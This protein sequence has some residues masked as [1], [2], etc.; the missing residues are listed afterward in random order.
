MQYT[1]GI[2]IV[3]LAD[4]GSPDVTIGDVVAASQL[5]A[6]ETG[7]PET[8]LPAPRT[9]RVTAPSGDVRIIWGMPFLEAITSGPVAA[10]D[11]TEIVE[12]EIASAGIQSIQHVSGFGRLE[13][14]GTLLDALS[15]DATAVPGVTLVAGE[16]LLVGHE[17]MW[18][19][20]TRL[21]RERPVSHLIGTAIRR[22]HTQASLALAVSRMAKRAADVRARAGASRRRGGGDE[23]PFVVLDADSRRALAPFARPRTWLQ[24]LTA[25]DIE[26]GTVGGINADEDEIDT[27]LDRI[28]AGANIVIDRSLPGMISVSTPAIAGG[29]QV[30]SYLATAVYDEALNRITLTVQS[31]GG[32]EPPPSSIIYWVAPDPLPR[33]A[34][35]VRVSANGGYPGYLVSLDDVFLG[36]RDITPGELIQ[37]LRNAANRYLVIEPLRPRARDFDIAVARVYVPHDDLANIMVQLETA[38]LFGPDVL[39]ESVADTRPGVSNVLGFGVPVSAP[40]FADIKPVIPLGISAYVAHNN[41]LDWGVQFNGELYKWAFGPAWITGQE[42]NVTFAPYPPAT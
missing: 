14:I 15:R 3:P 8:L 10:A 27:I 4:V 1:R 7:W 40:D 24:A 31:L 17:L 21:V 22:V 13:Q 19:D 39:P 12:A 26:G 29:G 41:A 32:A 20:G 37:T 6:E 9:W 11:N 30:P 2:P 25:A 34:D 18:H 42:F 33:D 28:L 23:R 36:A 35:R 5:A 38:T 16:A